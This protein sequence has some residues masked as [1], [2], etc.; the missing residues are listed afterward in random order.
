MSRATP[1]TGTLLVFD[2]PAT[3]TFT[4]STLA[5]CSD[6]GAIFIAG[7]VLDERHAESQAVSVGD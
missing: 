7:S 1:C 2:V 5:Q 4:A 3:D 6:C